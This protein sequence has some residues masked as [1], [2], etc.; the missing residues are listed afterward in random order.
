MTSVAFCV[1][2]CGSVECLVLLLKRGANPNYQ[3]I[4]G[5]TPLHLAARNGY[6]LP[7]GSF[8]WNTD[9]TVSNRLDTANGG[10]LGVKRSQ[11]VFRGTCLTVQA[12]EIL[13]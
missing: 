1:R 3:D 13:P 8:C 7:S 4:S 6:D 5:C 12:E 9:V 2:S 11:E 10:V